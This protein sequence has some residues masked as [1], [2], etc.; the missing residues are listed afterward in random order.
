MAV[1]LVLL[2]LLRLT[3]VLGID[4]L[5]AA[6]QGRDAAADARAGVGLAAVFGPLAGHPQLTA[7]VAVQL[8]R[9]RAGGVEAALAALAAGAMRP[10]A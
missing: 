2:Y 7:E 6:L 5:R 8:Q 9:L 4:P 10:R 3:D 1:V